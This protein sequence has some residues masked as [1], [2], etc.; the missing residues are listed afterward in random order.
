MSGCQQWNKE[1]CWSVEW[2]C[3]QKWRETCGTVLYT[4]N[5]VI[6]ACT[7]NNFA[8]SK[9]WAKR[10][11]RCRDD[12]VVKAHLCKLWPGLGLVISDA[13]YTW[14]LNDAVIGAEMMKITAIKAIANMVDF[15]GS[16][17]R[18]TIHS[19]EERRWCRRRELGMDDIGINMDYI[20]KV[21]KRRGL[22]YIRE[23]KMDYIMKHDKMI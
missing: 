2:V 4:M 14:L 8:K 17:P 7:C 20:V 3:R 18:S 12:G 9:I 5:R 16:T 21:A 13:M 1:K 10:W 19:V 11:Q 22:Y 15:C 23:K 6:T